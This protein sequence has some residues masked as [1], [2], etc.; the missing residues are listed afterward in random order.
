MIYREALAYAQQI[1]EKL[2][3]NDPRLEHT[4][5]LQHREGFLMQEAAFLMTEGDWLFVF[6]EHIAPLVYELDEIEK[7]AQFEMQY[8]AREE[9]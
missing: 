1:N 3:A 8:P 9:G 7:Y 4:V 5:F 2:R 6:G